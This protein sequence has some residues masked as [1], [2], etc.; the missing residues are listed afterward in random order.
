M[1]PLDHHFC[2]NIDVK[3]GKLI[4]DKQYAYKKGSLIATILFLK[5][6]S[7]DKYFRY[8]IRFVDGREKE[9]KF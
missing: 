2:N 1:T 6:Y 3:D 8:H 4:P 5:D 7:D 9:Y